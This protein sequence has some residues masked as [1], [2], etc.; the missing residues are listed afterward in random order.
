VGNA[1]LVYIY[2][3]VYKRDFTFGD[4][5]TRLHDYFRWKNIRLRGIDHGRYTQL[6]RKLRRK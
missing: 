1:I 3:M 2:F 5:S 4:W 6:L